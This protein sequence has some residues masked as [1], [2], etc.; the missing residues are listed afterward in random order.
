[1]DFEAM[2]DTEL[3]AFIQGVDVQ[4]QALKGQARAA[5]AVLDRK[6][7]ERKAAG[8]LASLT[9]IE[10]RALAQAIAAEGIASSEAVGTPG[11]R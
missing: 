6:V 10:R 2:T 4:V 1:M 3:E 8:T 7:A 9:D 11:Q 5:H